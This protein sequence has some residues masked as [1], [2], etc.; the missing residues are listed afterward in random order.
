MRARISSF[1]LPLALVSL[2]L[3]VPAGVAEFRCSSEISYKWAKKP[4]P[5]NPSHRAD[6][7]PPGSRNPA[8]TLS[9]VPP[10]PTPEPTIVRLLGLER[11]GSDEASARTALQMETD[12]QRIRASEACKRDHE[13][14]GTC[15]ALKMSSQANVLNSLSFSA[16][17]ELEKALAE[18]CRQQEGT[19]LGVDVSDP[20]CR[21]VVAVKPSA[22]PASEKPSDTKGSKEPA[23]D[24]KKK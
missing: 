24:G 4:S 22:S 5:A 1:Y 21:E 19:C 18:E 16:R 9:P 23:K 8:P 3:S 10:G 12:R 13:A 11:G 17:S 7:A 20:K 15:V 2:L 14:F 6:V